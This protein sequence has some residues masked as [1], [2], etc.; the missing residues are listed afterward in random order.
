[1]WLHEPK[2]FVLK[3]T[4]F[5][6]QWLLVFL[7]ISQRTIP[8]LIIW[9]IVVGNKTYSFSGPVITR[10][11]VRVIFAT[12]F[13]SISRISGVIAWIIMSTISAMT[14]EPFTATIIAISVPIWAF[15][16]HVRSAVTSV[17]F[18]RHY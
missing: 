13:P 2:S 3:K 15:T 7:R 14:P 6:D 9:I 5:Y 18:A 8:V 12:A 16:Y 17:T 10:S 1:M 4:Y 11:I